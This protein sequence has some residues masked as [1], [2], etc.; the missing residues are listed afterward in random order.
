VTLAIIRQ[1][2]RNSFRGLR[3]KSKRRVKNS[4]FMLRVEE[5]I[6]M[7]YSKQE[8]LKFPPASKN[9]KKQPKPQKSDKSSVNN[10]VNMST[11][12]LDNQKVNI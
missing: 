1:S 8:R 5:I 9:H 6:E 12:I 3:T 11:E 7:K 10:S 4:M 2:I